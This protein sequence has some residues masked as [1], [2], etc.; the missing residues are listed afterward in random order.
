MR[1]KILIG[2]AILL[3]A[4]IFTVRYFYRK[5]YQEFKDSVANYESLKSKKF[6]EEKR[7]KLNDLSQGD[8][9][10]YQLFSSQFDLSKSMEI[11]DTT[12]SLLYLSGTIKYKIPRQA[13]INCLHEKCQIDENN[14]ANVDKIT[15]K[16]RTLEGR[17]GETFR[18][19][20]PKLKD[21]K[22]YRKT[23]ITSECSEFFPDLFEITFDERSW[24]DFS[25]FMISFDSESKGIELQNSQVEKEF[26]SFVANT[27]SQLNSGATSFFNNLLDNKRS[28]I[29]TQ[30]SEQRSYN[31]AALGQINYALTRSK[32]DQE[33]F[34]SVANEAFEEQWKYNSLSTGA[35]PYS[36]CY[37]SSNYCSEYSCSKISVITG[38]SNDVLVTI[39]NVN[40]NVVRHGYINGGSS[41]T[42]NVPDGQYQVFF[43]SGNGWNPNKFM[44][45][46]TCGS[47]RGGFVSGENFT[48]DNYISL[49]S[50][51]M[52]YE[53]IL[54]ENGNL[55][56]QPSSMNEAFN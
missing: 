18:Q 28:Q 34:Q 53:L 44:T 21:E 31:S 22:L 33:S 47:L 50:Q 43:Y 14:T 49:Y 7:N 5:G 3:L 20:Y 9:K 42:F 19:W 8:Q 40:G 15:S 45:T 41:L 48:K 17:F 12:F 55:S 51:I 10:I 1:N 54:Q 25:D 24:N 46:T 4:F 32:F 6:D 11:R 35:M 30:Q 52:T 29:L 13:Y 16:E 27:R 38:G 39:K 23:K 26:S 56:T 36:Y 37:G 2:T